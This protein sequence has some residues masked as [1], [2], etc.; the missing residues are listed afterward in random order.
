MEKGKNIKLDAFFFGN[1]KHNASGE[2]LVNFLSRNRL[3]VTNTFFNI[4]S[5]EYTQ[6][7][8]LNSF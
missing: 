6:A 5:H 4:K 3:I 1:G 8:T 2:R 7:V